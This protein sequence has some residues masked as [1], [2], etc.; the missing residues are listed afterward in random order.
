MNINRVAIAGMGALGMLYG[1]FLIDAGEKNITYVMDEGRFE[2]YS[3]TEFYKNGRPYALPMVSSAQAQPADL[4]IVAVKYS[5][6]E[7]VLDVIKN[8][9]AEHTIILSVM[10]GVTSEEIIAERYGKEHLVYTVAQGMD[11]MKFGN[12]LEFTVMGELRIGCKEPCQEKNLQDLKEYFDRVKMPYTADPDIMHRL[13]SKFM[14]NVGINQACMVHETTY[15]GCLEKG[16]AN[17]TL[18]AA[19]REAAAV[20]N[21]EGIDLGEN[22]INEYIKI[23]RTLSPDGVPSMR[24]DAIRKV[25][26]EVDMFAGT[27]IALGKKHGIYV[28]T[29][30]FIYERVK[31]ME[32][33]Y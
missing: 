31:E 24:Q 28:P 25:P 22:D 19:M 23:L 30:E 33:N 2:K 14:L 4:V 27:V 18:F 16:G 6:L 1:T 10:N 3:G 32:S 20:A 15:G 29:N 21:A 5:G 12:N 9:V 26:S 13:W 7:A 8:C 11:A 17:R